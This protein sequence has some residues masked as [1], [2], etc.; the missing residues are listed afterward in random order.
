VQERVESR[1]ESQAIVLRSA[2]EGAR[3]AN[4]LDNAIDTEQA[5]GRGQSQ[6]VAVRATRT[7]NYGLY[8]VCTVTSQQEW[9]A[10]LSSAC[11]SST[12][13]QHDDAKGRSIYCAY[14]LG[15]ERPEGKSGA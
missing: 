4:Y 7:M 9:T 11:G 13:L 14:R 2:A 6:I 3:P 5:G 10:Q 15:G 12:G 8:C 1:S